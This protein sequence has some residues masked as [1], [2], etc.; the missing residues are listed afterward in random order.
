M[1][2]C[3]SQR[4]SKSSVA[5][6]SMPTISLLYNFALLSPVIAISIGTFHAQTDD[7]GINCRARTKIHMVHFHITLFILI[8]SPE[9][10]LQTIPVIYIDPVPCPGHK[11]CRRIVVKGDKIIVPL[12]HVIKG[13]SYHTTLYRIYEGL[14]PACG[15]IPYSG[16]STLIPSISRLIP[17]TGE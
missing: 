7:R 9:Y 5:S 17:S 1:S 6:G 4:L 8:R 12:I 15:T 13:I 2:A 16:R 11:G 14:L 3:V 10:Y